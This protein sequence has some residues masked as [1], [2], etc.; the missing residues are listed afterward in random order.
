MASIASACAGTNARGLDRDAGAASRVTTDGGGLAADA[1][2]AVAGTIGARGGTVSTLYFAV[3]GDTRPATVDDTAGYPL[4]IISKIF[5]DLESLDPAP[6]F[7]V[8]TG[9]YMFASTRGGQAA[10]QLALYLH[11]RAAFS[12]IMFP[13]M[14]NH[15]CTGATASNCGAGNADGVT[16][17][18]SQFLA[19]MLEPIG[20]TQPYYSF[21]VSAASGAWTA[22]F[23]VVAAN[24]WD[25][26]QAHWLEATLDRSTT[27]TFIVRHEPASAIAAPGV[28]PAEQIQ[29][30]H[31]YT[32]SIVGHAHTYAK[33]GP[34]EVVIGNGGAPLTSSR[35]NYGFGLVQQRPDG[36]IRFD[37]VDYA[38]MQRDTTFAFAVNADGSPA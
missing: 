22:K 37:V 7:G 29:S 11:A 25:D 9:D 15:E 19:K 26:V 33:T 32:L 16:E 4:A 2:G 38:T 21:G 24:A 18:Y 12:G 14:G 30:L 34:R 6:V 23:V 20:Q 5:E 13:A 10:P 3:V 31:P 8:S 36:S 17:N 28:I 27:Y 35:A 1:S